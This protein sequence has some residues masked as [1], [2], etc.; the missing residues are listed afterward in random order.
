MSE[1]TSRKGAILLAALIA[2]ATF[3]PSP[4]DAETN[5]MT[6]QQ[7]MQAQQRVINRAK[8]EP[9]DVKK[10]R[11][12]RGTTKALDQS[13]VDQVRTQRTTSDLERAEATKQRILNQQT[14]KPC[15]NCR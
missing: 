13:G 5:T 11:D 7:K 4:S 3:M 15:K 10:A 8:D 6:P 14:S 12:T 2:A 9:P 1:S